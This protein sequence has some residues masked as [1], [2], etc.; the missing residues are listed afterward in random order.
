MGEKKERKKISHK[1]NL[2]VVKKY[3][4]YII[5]PVATY[6]TIITVSSYDK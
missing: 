5:L 3:K 2:A 1:A 6:R 4:V